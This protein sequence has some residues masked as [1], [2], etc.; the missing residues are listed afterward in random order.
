MSRKTW[1]GGTAIFV[2]LI[3]FPPQWYPQPVRMQLATWLGADAYRALPDSAPPTELMSEIACPE[4]LLGWREAQEIAGIQ[5]R[6]S[7]NCIADDP[8]AVAAFVR[9]TNN[10]PQSVLMQSG[11][12]QDA[13]VKGRDLDNDGDPDEIH[14][15]LEV[16]ELNGASPDSGNLST[17]Y[18]IAPGIKPGLWVF[19]PKLTGMATKNFESSQARSLLRLPSPAIRIEQGDRVQITLENGHYMPHTVHLHGV[20]HPFQDADGEGNDGVPLT[21]EAPVLPGQARTYNLQPRQAGTMFY[22]CHVQ[23]NV[24]VMMGLQGL[25]IVEENRPNNWVQT[26][27]IGAGQVRYPSV[28]VKEDYDHEYDL[29][30][31]DLDRD[32]SNRIQSTNDPRLVTKSLHRDYNIATATSEFFTLNGKSFPYTFRESLVIAK[33]NDTIRLRI[34]N[35]GNNGIALHT[36]GHKTTATHLDGVSVQPN[37]QEVRDVFWMATAQRL[38]LKLETTN[39]GLHSFGEGVWLMHDHQGRGVTTDGIGPG[40]N[41][42]AIVYESYLQDNGWPKTFGVSWDPYFSEEYYRKEVPVWQSYAK[43]LSSEVT[44]DVWLILR[45]LGLG[46]A[47]GTIAALLILQFQARRS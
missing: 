38:D 13:I 31:Q 1:I 36:H 21:S 18:A 19:V 42:S 7:P 41:I 14:I 40:G 5:I 32:L 11:L 29:H 43:N 25:F 28:A 9:G 35:G 37:A 23:P 10:I 16:A 17:Q 22:H 12:T 26:F 24:H 3:S 20:D 30:Y 46:L 6:R 34:V 8:Y 47:A 2:L 4:D 15:R 45:L 44:F 39:D 33:P 27:N